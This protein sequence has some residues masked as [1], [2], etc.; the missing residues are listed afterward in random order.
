V[1]VYVC[2]NKCRSASLEYDGN[3][4]QRERGLMCYLSL[5]ISSIDEFVSLIEHNSPSPLLLKMTILEGNSPS[6]K[7]DAHIY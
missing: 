5:E 2:I 4:I 6:V 3:R 1:Y 7:F